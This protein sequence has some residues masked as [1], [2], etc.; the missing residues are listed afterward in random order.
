MGKSHFIEKNL[1]KYHALMP[2]S[3][4]NQKLLSN[5]L[6]FNANTGVHARF[7]QPTKK[8]ILTNIYLT[9]TTAVYVIPCKQWYFCKRY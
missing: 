6:I 7:I 1:I 3:S 9:P 4:S 8:K 2:R 5:I